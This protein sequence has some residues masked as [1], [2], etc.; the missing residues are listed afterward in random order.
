MQYFE[1][2]GGVRFWFGVLL[3]LGSLAVVF[4]VAY[5]MKHE[6]KAP[7]PDGEVPEH[8][9]PGLPLV[10]KMLYLG[11][12]IWFLAVLYLMAAGGATI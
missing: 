9:E 12:A 1:L 10:L 4:A 6:R 7:G 2:Y 3:S 5:T 8:D 11:V